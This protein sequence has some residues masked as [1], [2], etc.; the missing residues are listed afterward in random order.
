MSIDDYIKEWETKAEV[1]Y[2]VIIRL[3][4][5]TL[6]AHSAICFHC[7]QLVE[8]YLKLFLIF[9]GKIPNRTHNIELLLSECAETD[10]VFDKIDPKNLS[11]FGVN[12]RYPG[13]F[14]NPSNSETLE[15]ITIAQNVRS[16][17]REKL[18]L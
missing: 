5:G 7:Q 10:K 16:L 4:E 17:I 2:Q 8:K 6:I 18:S 13:D 3:S 14:Y 15:Y 11:D 1:D 9:N 12:I